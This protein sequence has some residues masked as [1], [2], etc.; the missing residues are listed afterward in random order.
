MR[1]GGIAP[2][3]ANGVEAFAASPASAA[4]EIQKP[5]VYPSFRAED[6]RKT[7]GLIFAVLLYPCLCI[8]TFSPMLFFISS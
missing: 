6:V 7:D 1:V 5:S 2:I 4:P 8:P 3:I